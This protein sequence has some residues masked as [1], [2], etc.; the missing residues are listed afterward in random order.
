M[1]S[2]TADSV[3]IGH[4][5]IGLSTAYEL[6]RAGLSCCLVGA[7]R[8]GAASGAAAGLLAPSIGRLSGSVA[9]FFDASLDLY[10]ALIDTLR[11]FDPELL[12]LT[13][14][15]EVSTSESGQRA[16]PAGSTRL[17]PADLA[18]LE[19]S[20]DATFGGVLHPRDGA[21]DNVRLV[22][23]LRHAIGGEPRVRHISNDPVAR[24]DVETDRATVTLESGARLSAANIVLAAG[25]WSGGLIAGLPR[26]LPLSPLKGQML[27]VASSAL[28][29]P[30][31]DDNVYLVP[32]GGEI[33]IG[34]TVEDAGFDVSTTPDAIES[35]RRAAVRLVP[36]LAQAGVSR[37]WAGL[38]PATPDRLPI[39]G[40]DPERPRLIY[41]CGH[42]KNGILLAPA[43]ARAVAALAGGG[44]AAWDLAPFSI[45]RFIDSD[46]QIS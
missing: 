33:A 35:L 46:P 28:R 39:I 32:R 19:A 21:V 8:E 1:T 37:R 2:R 14:L 20:V 26:V 41:A 45:N 43:T 25:A 22:A 23:A 24:I 40:P 7:Q 29:H 5:V 44:P 34:A 4:G 6:A 15:V 3:I 18:E 10:P 38:R 42:T 13:G 17:S 30:V 12:L 11:E 27:A 9:A 31:M 36:S 16:L